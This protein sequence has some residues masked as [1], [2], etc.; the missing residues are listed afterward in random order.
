M[1]L[2]NEKYVLI[3]KYIYLDCVCCHLTQ[4]ARFCLWQT[5]LL[6]T[7]E[8]PLYWGGAFVDVGY[9]FNLKNDNV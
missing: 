3:C 5:N 9:D 6:I 4:C 1:D 7:P 8:F 2:P